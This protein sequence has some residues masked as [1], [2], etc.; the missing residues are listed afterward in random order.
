M[1]LDIILY[2]HIEN[3]LAFMPHIVTLDH[4]IE[5]LAVWAVYIT[6]P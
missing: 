2:F 6:K 5:N 3:Y 1:F 4:R